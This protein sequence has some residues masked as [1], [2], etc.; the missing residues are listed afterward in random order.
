[1]PEIGQAYV[2]V[3]GDF[4][5]LQSQMAK[6]FAPSTMSKF[7]K[8]AGLAAGGAL[9][10]GFAAAGIGKA[11]FEVGKEFDEA[12]DSI[13]VQTGATGKEFRKLKG[14]FRDTIG[15][16]PTDFE[17]AS[18]AVAGL[19]QRLDITG[20]PLARLTKQMT[21]LSE[22]TGT[23]ITEN[24]E[25]VTRLFG[26]WSVK[27]KD[28]TETLDGLF[29]IAQQ[30]GGSV[31]ELSRLLVQFGAP[32][33]NLGIDLDFAAAMFANFEKS[34]VNISTVLSGLRLSVGNL[35]QPTDDLKQLLEELGINAAKPEKALAEVFKQIKT[36]DDQA[37]KSLA[38]ELF[39]KRA[40]PG[41]KRCR[42]H[43]ALC[44]SGLDEG[45]QVGRRDD[46]KHRATDP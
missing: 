46:P 40:G 21:A 39:G 2:Q 8:A 11:L 15:T 26:D 23:D 38:I 27:T 14:A 31:S 42:R 19:N 5:P 18:K 1:M 20:K 6:A 37:S 25:A 16:I 32:L 45:V 7:G 34:G 22:V 36:L 9:A 4:T 17:T 44:A 33:R 13:K 43:R 3:S 35:A 41:P 12:Y 10:V 29:R 28:Q 30:T 24:V